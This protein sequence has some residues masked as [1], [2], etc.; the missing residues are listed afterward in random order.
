[1]ASIMGLLTAIGY[2]RLSSDEVVCKRSVIKYAAETVQYYANTKYH[3]GRREE[4]RRYDTQALELRA[5]AG[6]A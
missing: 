4:Q 3:A 5:K 2:R 6:E 1:M